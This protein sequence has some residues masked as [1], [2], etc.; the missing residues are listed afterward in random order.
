ML[1]AMDTRLGC[2]GFLQLR[3]LCVCWEYSAQ[4]LTACATGQII[5]LTRCV[6][7]QGYD[8]YIHA[9]HMYK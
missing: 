9:E 7:L 1:E 5:K 8:D 6:R 4:C 3:G 2:V